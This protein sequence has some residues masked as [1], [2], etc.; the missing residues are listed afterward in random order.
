MKCL[1]TGRLA[2]RLRPLGRMLLKWTGGSY[3]GTAAFYYTCSAA[4]RHTS[5][6]LQL[7]MLHLH[8]YMPIPLRVGGW[9]GL[10]SLLASGQSWMQWTRPLQHD[11]KFGW[12]PLLECRA[13]TLPLY[14]N[15]RLGRKVDFA[16]SKIPS[17]DKSTKKCIYSVPA[18]ETA[19]DCAKLGCQFMSL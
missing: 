2:N 9:V 13:V 19:K 18:Q 10:S 14:E 15:A 16:R 3:N 6:L 17:G 11:A 5:P 4:C 8:Q 12:G 7:A 1:Y